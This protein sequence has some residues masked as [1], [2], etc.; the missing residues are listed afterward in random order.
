MPQLYFAGNGWLAVVLVWVAGLLLSTVFI[1]YKKNQC[2]SDHETDLSCA[3]DMKIEVID[4]QDNSRKDTQDVNSECC[5][6][7]QNTE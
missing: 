4:D 1:T 5:P 2:N 7:M 6:N 3:F